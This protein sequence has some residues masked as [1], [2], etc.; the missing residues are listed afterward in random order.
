M[1]FRLLF[2]EHGFVPN[3]LTQLAVMETVCDL[4]QA[5][6]S[7][8]LTGILFGDV[9]KAFDSLN[10]T[11]LISKLKNVRLENNIIDWFSSYLDRKQILRYKG[12][13]SNELNVI[14]G[15]PQGSIGGPTLFIF[16]INAIFD[17]IFDV[18]IKMF[19]DDCVLYKSGPNW[20][21]IHDPC[22]ICWITI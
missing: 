21:F 10:H 5:M 13:S 20:N 7:N 14:S 16:Y 18:K 12:A 3:R 17:N 9:R 8:L 2:F 22:K 1:I 11:I 15:I 6:D 4:Y 19:A